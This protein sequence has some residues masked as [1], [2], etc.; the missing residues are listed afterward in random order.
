MSFI[1][2]T[3]QFLHREHSSPTVAPN[4]FPELPHSLKRQSGLSTHSLS[5]AA[6][7]MRNV[8]RELRCARNFP[9]CRPGLYLLLSS[10]CTRR[11]AFLPFCVDFGMHNLTG[12]Q[13]KP[14]FRR[15][16]SGLPLGEYKRTCS[17]THLQLPSARRRRM[18]T[19]PSASLSI[20]ALFFY[21]F[22]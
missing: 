20:S 11:H 17:F 2:D 7:S 4:I 21:T 3:T 1:P 5:G 19:F 9:A 10:T 6:K 15:D 14:A 18:K 16:L 8:N 12:R 13:V 22:A